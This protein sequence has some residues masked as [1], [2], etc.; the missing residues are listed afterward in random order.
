LKTE[1]RV[2]VT[3][4]RVYFGFLCKDPDPRRI[5]VH[6][7]RRDGVMTGDDT[8]SIVLDTYGDH[9]TG[10]FL[11]INAAG[12]R[13]DGLIPTRR[14]PRSTGNGIWGCAHSSICGWVVRGGL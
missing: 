5:A 6:T 12:A 8:V 4:D 2:V 1:V 10:Y 3:R 9:R 7:M 11:K 14:A 13:A